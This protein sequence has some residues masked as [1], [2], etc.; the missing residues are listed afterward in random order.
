MIRESSTIID[1]NDAHAATAPRTTSTSTC[2]FRKR[3]AAGGRGAGA[4][5]G[6]LNGGACAGKPGRFSENGAEH[7]DAP[8]RGMVH[9]IYSRHAGA[10]AA[11]ADVPEVAAGGLR[12]ALSAGCTAC[13]EHVDE[14]H[15]DSA[16]H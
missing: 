10:I 14:E 2:A 15:P 13:H 4:R 3:L 6:T 5:C 7:P 11:G 16:R 12:H 8:G 1:Q 9:R